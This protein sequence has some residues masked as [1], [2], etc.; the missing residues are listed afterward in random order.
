P[1]APLP[2]D[3]TLWAESAVTIGT[4][5]IN[6]IAMSLRNGIKVSGTLEFKGGAEKPASDKISSVVLSL[7]PADGRTAAATNSVRRR[8]E[9]TGTFTTVGVPPGR[10]VLRVQ[11]PP[12]GWA[13]L[14]AMMGGRDI[15]DEAIELSGGDAT[16]VA[17][18]FTDA[19][20]ELRGVVTNA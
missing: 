2:N 7:E 13:L 17:I 20:T 9:T 1:G 12:Q 6:D 10:Y 16:G 15:T 8:V 3:P 14:G 5:D 11:N 19:P 18:T 4:N